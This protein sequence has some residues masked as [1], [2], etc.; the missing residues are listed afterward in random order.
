MVLPDSIVRL[1]IYSIYEH[2]IQLYN[3][4]RT[5]K[6]PHWNRCNHCAH[7]LAT[8][9]K[10]IFTLR[11]VHLKVSRCV[12]INVQL[13]FWHLFRIKIFDSMAYGAMC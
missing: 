9:L 4:A 7:G 5:C 1:S 8:G 13:K 2:Y 10:D 6:H 12:K 11:S 3:N